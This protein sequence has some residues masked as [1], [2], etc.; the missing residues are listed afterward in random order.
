MA[1]FPRTQVENVSLPRMLIGSNWRRGGSHTGAAADA[2]IK[3]RFAEPEAVAGMIQAYLS[4]DIDAVMAPLEGQ[5]VFINGLKLAQERTGK[6][7]TLIDTPIVDVGDSRERREAAQTTIRRSAHNG[8]RLCLLHHVCAE[9]LVSKLPRRMDRL[10]DYLAMIRQAGMIPGL[11]AHMPELIL[12]SDENEYDVQTYVQIY[13]PLGFM[14]Q[15]EIETV[16]KVIENAK[17]PVMTIKSMAA[18]RVTPY[19]GITF[20]Y[21]T[22]RPCDMVTVGAHTPQEVHEDV[23]SALAALDRRFPDLA[24]RASPNGREGSIGPAGN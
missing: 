13:N 3:A 1:A 24:G 11:T 23:E 8:A 2:M 7:L 18:G 22:L 21:A 4:Y 16:R 5:P 12:Y 10:P 6:S 19:V 15:V 17:K 14:M 9:Q 20:A